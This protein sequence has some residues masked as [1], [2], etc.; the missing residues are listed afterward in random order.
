MM[1]DADRQ[2]PHFGAPPPGAAADAA[3]VPPADGGLRDDA[4]EGKAPVEDDVFEGKGPVE[5]DVFEGKGPVEDDVFEGKGPVED[6]VFDP[7]IEETIARSESADIPAVDRGGLEVLTTP[8]GLFGHFSE[9]L[10]K[11]AVLF[12]QDGRLHLHV[13]KG[14]RR[15]LEVRA[16]LEALG[17]AHDLLAENGLPPFDGAI[18]DRDAASIAAIY[19]RAQVLYGEEDASAEELQEMEV[20]AIALFR[21]AA[22]EGATDFHI[23]VTLRRCQLRMRV[24]G[25]LQHLD[26]FTFTP[27]EGRRLLR[28]LFAMAD[29]AEPTYKPTDSQLA[30]LGGDQRGDLPAGI[31]AVRIQYIPLSQ[32]GRYAAIRIQYIPVLSGA[33][34]EDVDALGYEPEQMEAIRRIRRRPNGAFL[35]CGPTGS[36]KSRTLQVVVEA[37]D[38]EQGQTKAIFTVEDPVEYPIRGAAQR[39]VI[40]SGAAEDRKQKFQQ[41]VNDA[42]RQDPDVVMISEL[43][44]RESARMFFTLAQTGHLTLSTLHANSALASL[45]RL[46]DE[47]VEAFKLKDPSLVIG[48]VAQRLVPILCPHCAVPLADAM[49]SDDTATRDVAVAIAARF[50]SIGKRYERVRL[51]GP[52]CDFALKSQRCKKGFFGRRVVAEVVETDEILLELAARDKRRTAHRYWL[53]HKGGRTMLEIAIERSVGGE[54]DP[55]DVEKIIGPI[56][57]D[58]MRERMLAAPM[59]RDQY[60]QILEAVERGGDTA[61]EKAA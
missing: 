2:E 12:R 32:G 33:K 25:D 5:D 31:D 56:E 3:G 60:E 30:R 29:N 26:K 13:V 49:Q 47:G 18:V 21:Y 10:R 20:K 50:E 9:N 40:T 27:D 44:D 23:Q 42:L 59:K 55:R 39:P 7:E 4:I 58:A 41:A 36:G 8:N 28:A 45:Q 16:L 17:R 24:D 11:S 6:D 15:D 22:Q 1:Q 61:A 37:I 14:H 51:R 46:R 48:L 57:L 35:V 54:I 38:R 19:A 53:E 34:D 43:R 52:G